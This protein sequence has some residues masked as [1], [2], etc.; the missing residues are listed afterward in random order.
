MSLNSILS[1]AS[2]GLASINAQL[3]VVSQNV[4]NAS[5]PGYAREVVGLTDLTAG[6]VGYGVVTGPATQEVDTALTAA[7]TE[8]NA[9]VAG[10]Q[11][12]STA[13]ANVDTA[14]GTTGAGNDL[15]SRVGALQDAFTTL[16]ADP[17]NQAQQANLVTAAGKLAGASRPRRP[18]IPRNARRRRTA[19]SVT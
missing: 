6:G 11:I 17:S 3:G 4:A 15:S 5:T 19:W 1:T 7:L 16:A 12:R 18:P 9:A 8:Q 13:L 14:Q 10:A 2:S